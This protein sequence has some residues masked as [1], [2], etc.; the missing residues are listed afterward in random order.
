MTHVNEMLVGL[1]EEKAR[2]HLETVRWGLWR[3]WNGS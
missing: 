2:E 1:H 3:Y